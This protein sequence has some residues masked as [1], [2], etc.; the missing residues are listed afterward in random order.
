M[1]G[2]IS[3][4]AWLTGRCPANVESILCSDS[5]DSIFISVKD[6]NSVKQPYLLVPYDKSRKQREQEVFAA[7]LEKGIA[8]ALADRSGVPP[9]ALCAHDL[10][11]YRFDTDAEIEDDQV[12]Y[13]GLLSL[14]DIAV[15]IG[16]EK[17][18]KSNFLLVLAI[19]A[20]I[21]RDYLNFRFTAKGPM[22]I[23][24][25]DYESKS[26]SLKKRYDRIAD[27][28][29]LNAEERA[30][31][32]QNLNVI[33]V[34]RIRKSGIKFPKFPYKQ[35]PEALKFWEAL[36]AANPADIYIIDPFRSLHGGDENDSMIESML[37]E[38]QRV[39]R[40]A[41]LIVAHHMRKA[42]DNAKYLR[43]A[44]ID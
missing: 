12:I 29:N 40:G 20:A 15:W 8:E 27:A 2:A 26:R 31:L 25:I 39:F 43:L 21:G 6:E 35:D 44:V 3:I 23:V 32:K 28:M 42:G 10:A 4:A 36:V 19:C 17:A 22:R 7:A 11:S 9:G 30:L 13:D 38:L 41:T 18:R 1:D 5:D 34:R 37:T 24:I 14:S 33:E 16:R